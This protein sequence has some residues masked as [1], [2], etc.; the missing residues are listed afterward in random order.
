MGFREGGT[1]RPRQRMPCAERT[2]RPLDRRGK[3]I[4]QLIHGHKVAAYFGQCMLCRGQHDQSFQSPGVLI[5]PAIDLQAAD[6]HELPGQGLHAPVVSITG[7]AFRAEE[8]P[9]RTHSYVQP[10]LPAAGSRDEI[11]HLLG[12]AAGLGPHPGSGFKRAEL[13]ERVC[14][15]QFCARGNACGGQSLTGLA[16]VSAFG[17]DHGHPVVHHAPMFWRNQLTSYPAADLAHCASAFR[18]RRLA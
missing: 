9:G 6:V 1:S 10:G 3:D 16:V 18:L 13:G 17:E 8:H 5:A 2:C 15:L 12:T 7:Q 11:C 14:L 4:G